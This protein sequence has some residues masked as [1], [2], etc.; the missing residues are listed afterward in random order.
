MKRL[1]QPVSGAEPDHL[2]LPLQHLTLVQHGKESGRRK[3]VRIL[4]IPFLNKEERSDTRNSEP[5]SEAVP[6]GP[7]NASSSGWPRHDKKIVI[8]AKDRH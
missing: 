3:Q 1:V 5:M 7:H 2:I 8:H 4:E 6:V